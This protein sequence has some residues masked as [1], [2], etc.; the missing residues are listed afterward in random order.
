MALVLPLSPACLVCGVPFTGLS[1]RL[2]ELMGLGRNPNNPELCNRCNSHFVAG[3]IQSA[4]ALALKLPGDLQL[5]G[6]PLEASRSS[7]E[8]LIA[9]LERCLQGMGAHVE[10]QRPD[11]DGLGLIAYFN[12]PVPVA[13]PPRQA[14]AA[15]REVLELIATEE[16]IS[17][18]RQ[19]L[20]AGVAAG[21]VETVRVGP[22]D[23]RLIGQ[24]SETASRIA[25]LSPPGEI[26]VDAPTLT[27]AGLASKG[28]P[29]RWDRA[30]SLDNARSFERPGG[31]GGGGRPPAAALALLLALVAAPCAA[32][33]SLGPAALAIGAG[34]LFTALV[35]A[36]K[37]I[38]MNTGLRVTLAGLALILATGNLIATERRLRRQLPPVPGLQ[39]GRPLRFNRR[40][41][42]EILLV[43]L[44]TLLVYGVVFGE[45]L[46]RVAVM[47]MPAL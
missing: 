13:D 18:V 26:S 4:S 19:P 2:A 16:R 46:L 38:G 47:R 3:D 32:M 43:R 21:F 6:A 39:G 27:A 12:V 11:A 45:L 28:G 40:P 36:L 17:R 44:L 35:P 9:R 30:Y 5:G 31:L 8:G 22:A 29:L 23:L 15:A 10:R 1:G 34:A 20:R 14:V 41:G 25:S 42:R 33:L 24:V 7:Q 37:T